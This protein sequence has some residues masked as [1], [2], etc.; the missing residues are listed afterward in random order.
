MQKPY[1]LSIRSRSLASNVNLLQPGNKNN[2][3]VHTSGLTTSLYCVLEQ[4]FSNFLGWRPRFAMCKKWWP[5]TYIIQNFLMTEKKKVITTAHVYKSSDFKLVTLRF[6][7]IKFSKTS[8]PQNF[9]SR[10]TVWEALS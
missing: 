4:G 3:A 8:R 2:C 10:P 1:D 7:L 6:G 5:H 9:I